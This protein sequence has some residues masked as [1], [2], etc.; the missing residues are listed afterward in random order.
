MKKLI[1]ISTWILF[2]I[3][4]SAQHPLIGTWEMVSISGTNADG[5][6]FYLDTTTVRETKIITPTHYILLA[7]DKEKDQWTMNRCYFGTVSMT[8]SKYI[9]TPVMSSLRIFENV[10]TDFT[11]KV[12]GDRFIQSGSI[13]RPDGKKILLDQFIFAR[14]KANPV[15]A[16]APYTGTW[17]LQEGESSEG[18]LVITPTHWM[19]IIRSGEKLIDASGGTLDDTS[20]KPAALVQFG[21]NPTVG[22]KLS[23]KPDGKKLKFDAYT[24]ERVD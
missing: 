9:E 19:Q 7:L 21:S 14:A 16:A 4:A 22:K 1:V 18:M 13:T 10:I 8:D 5:E 3:T 12:E 23:I 6:K 2:A 11:W 20:G 15:A 17:K 24:F